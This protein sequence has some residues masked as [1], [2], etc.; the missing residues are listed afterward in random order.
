MPMSEP[1]YQDNAITI[2]HADCRELL[3]QLGI[4]AD[5]VL[6]DPPWFI[7][8]QVMI[9]RS[10]NPKFYKYTG[11]DINLDFGT[12]DHF[13]SE[14]EY[15]NFTHDWMVKAIACLRTKGHFISFF[16]EN[17]VSFLIEEGRKQGLAMRQ[18]LYWLKANPVP[19]ARKVDFMVA[20]EHACWFTKGDKSKATFNYQL[21]Q[22]AN[23]VHCAIPGHTTKDDG[24]RIHPTQKPFTVLAV[25]INYLTN[26]GD[27]I[28]DP[29]LGSGVTCYTA[30][31]LGRKSIGIEINEQYCEAAAKRCLQM[32][33]PL[34]II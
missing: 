34:N 6:T 19:R 28:L 11:K 22:Q 23:Y 12:W 33:L 3:P 30:K 14:A 17:K 10:V 27:L 4:E 2:Y 5:L 15:E 18:H 31:K 26:P 21:G 9:H 29:F 24:K 20:L 16:D 7:S 1:Y 13:E 25:W 32:I 8:Q